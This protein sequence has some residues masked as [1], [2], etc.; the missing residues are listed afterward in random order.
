M[1]ADKLNEW[2]RLDGLASLI[3]SE[4]RAAWIQ[5]RYPASESGRPGILHTD[6]RDRG[7]KR[8]IR[9]TDDDPADV[10]VSLPAWRVT[11]E[12]PG[13]ESAEELE[14]AVGAAAD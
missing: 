2:I 6:A 12:F 3:V 8:Q 10:E 4:E 13:D 11:S 14:I 7:S 1:G 9:K 5:R